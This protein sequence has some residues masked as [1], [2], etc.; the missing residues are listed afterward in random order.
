[1]KKD[2]IQVSNNCLMELHDAMA[3]MPDWIVEA[4][5][6]VDSTTQKS[7]GKIY[8]PK[9]KDYWYVEGSSVQFT[10]QAALEQAAFM[11]GVL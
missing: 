5:F 11:Y 2:A 8:R 10:Q 7:C 9:G 3:S 4:Y 1:M 6:L